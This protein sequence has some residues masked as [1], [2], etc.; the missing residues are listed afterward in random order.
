[1]A[2]TVRAVEVFVADVRNRPGMLARVLEALRNAQANLEFVIARRIT[3]D[4]SRI[5]V[6]PLKGIAQRRAAADVG[7]VPAVGLH[8]VRIEGP[9]RAGL[10]ADL[11]RA[12]AAAEINLRGMS[13]ATIG[14]KSVIYLAFESQPDADQGT[15]VVRAALRRK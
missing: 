9:D 6:A 10:A 15:R 14:R 4:T 2:F 3:E 12:L 5:F 13:A 7:M 8:T 1:M 11:S